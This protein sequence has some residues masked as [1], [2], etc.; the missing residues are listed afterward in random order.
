M[1]KFSVHD[2]IHIVVTDNTTMVY[3][4]HYVTV[5]TIFNMFYY[6]KIWQLRDAVVITL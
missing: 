4:V 2:W 1:N 3:V 5:L 6:V